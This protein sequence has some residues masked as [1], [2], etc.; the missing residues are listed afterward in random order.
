M[1]TT[2]SKDALAQSDS[3]L[4]TSWTE[5]ARTGPATF[6]SFIFLLISTKGAAGADHGWEA[7][8]W[9]GGAVPGL[10]AGA[11]VAAENEVLQPDRAAG[12]ATGE[13]GRAGAEDDKAGARAGD[14]QE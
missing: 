3:L 4:I 6:A 14:V 10:E 8:P 9:V 1:W 13:V 12:Q 7:E 11:R 5:G 2:E